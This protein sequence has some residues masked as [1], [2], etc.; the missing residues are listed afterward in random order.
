MK[1]GR[2]K[3]RTAALVLCCRVV[4]Q[5]APGSGQG[6]ITGTN[7]QQSLDRPLLASVR[8]GGPSRFLIFTGQVLKK[9]ADGSL[10]TWRRRVCGQLC[11]DVPS[12]IGLGLERFIYKLVSVVTVGLPQAS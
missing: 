8:V 7:C 1:R 11:F 5:D 10:T 2:M 3:R 9:P 4:G 12:K 6:K